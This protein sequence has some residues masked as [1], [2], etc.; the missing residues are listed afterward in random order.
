MGD[1]KFRFTLYRDRKALVTNIV[2]ALAYFVF[3]YI[4]VYELARLGY[5]GD[6]ILPP[7]VS[8]ASPIWTVI[9]LNTGLMFWRFF[10]R[11]MSV[12]RIYG[13]IQG[14]MSLLR[15]PIGNLINSYATL[16]GISQFA[17]AV[18]HDRTVAWDKT[19]HTFPSDH[20][21][22]QEFEAVDSEYQT[23]YYTPDHDQWPPRK[24]RK[25]SS[26]STT[27]KRSVSSS[28]TS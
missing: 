25:K 21:G 10:H 1:F 15:F 12:G 7:I 13:W 14:L 6:S 16:R 22:P 19:S 26:T 11:A 8:T 28:K 27:K 9:I 2:N 23:P 18:L 17:V 3:L 24:R 20:R 5:A 4:L